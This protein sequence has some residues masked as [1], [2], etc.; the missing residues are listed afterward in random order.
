MLNLIFMLLALSPV[1]TLMAQSPSEFCN[2]HLRY[3]FR[4]M[5]VEAN[6]I[7][8]NN[9]TPSFLACMEKRAQTTSEDVVKA[10]YKC[11]PRSTVSTTPIVDPLYQNFNSCSGQLQVGALMRPDRAVEICQWDSSPLIISCLTGLVQKAR[12]HPEHAI[13]YC[14]FANQNYRNEIPTFVACAEKKSARARSV[15]D[16][17]QACHEL[18]LNKLIKNPSPVVVQPPVARVEATPSVTVPSNATRVR[19][20]PTPV[21]I[22]VQESVQPDVVSNQPRLSADAP[23]NA[24]NLQID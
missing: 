2:G 3:W 17:A 6:H 7:C 16:V 4:A 13:Q 12:F 8:S 9:S 18:V 1:Q 15:L 22:Q 5:P 14:S 19:N 21:Q 11:D 20:V 23:S 24:E 10:A